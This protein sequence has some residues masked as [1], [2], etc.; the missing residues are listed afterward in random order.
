MYISTARCFVFVLKQKFYV[1]RQKLPKNQFSERNYVDSIL[2]WGHSKWL[3][4]SKYDVFPVLILFVF[5]ITM[6]YPV[7][8]HISHVTLQVVYML[9]YI[10]KYVSRLGFDFLIVE[11]L[12]VEDSGEVE[13]NRFEIYSLN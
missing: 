1:L 8:M 7:L 2:E 13:S 10:L 9:F 5:C 11:V 4:L 3:L 6:H 12:I